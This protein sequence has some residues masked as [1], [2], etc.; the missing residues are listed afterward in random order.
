MCFLGAHD[1]VRA[2]LSQVAVVFALGCIEGDLPWYLTKGF[3]C[4]KQGEVFSDLVRQQIAALAPQSM[5]LVDAFGIPDYL[6]N[7][8]IALDWVKF[9]EGD[10]QGELIRSRL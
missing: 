5:N 10:N 3:I 1:L 4:L 2:I 6:I 9:N 7:A 8:P